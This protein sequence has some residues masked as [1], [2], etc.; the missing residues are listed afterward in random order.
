VG[1]VV[2]VVVVVVPQLPLP[3]LGLTLSFSQPEKLL[4]EHSSKPALARR[5]ME[6]K[7][8]VLIKKGLEKMNW[9]TKKQETAS[10]YSPPRPGRWAR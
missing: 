8:M 1:V 4:M 10:G 9:A 3:P 5:R 2:V 7:R 6:V